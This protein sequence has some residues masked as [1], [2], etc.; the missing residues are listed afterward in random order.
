MRTF[1][2]FIFVTVVSLF[3]YN[4]EMDDFKSFLN[5]ETRPASQTQEFTA[6]P[7]RLLNTDTT[8]ADAE[9]EPTGYSTQRNNY[10]IF[11]TYRV[12]RA[13]DFH[14]AEFGRYLGIATMFFE[15]GA[16]DM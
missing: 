11:S 2:I 12:F 15:L 4:P 6:I 10:L 7:D 5:K 9:E 8:A 1:Y 3:F 16:T 14:E 13:D